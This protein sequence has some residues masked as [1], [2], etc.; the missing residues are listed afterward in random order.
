MYSTPESN[1][2]SFPSDLAPN[3]HFLET[4]AAVQNHASEETVAKNI[5]DTSP[6]QG[7]A[8]RTD[9]NGGKEKAK[10][11]LASV[12]PTKRKAGYFESA[13][14]PSQ[15]TRRSS[16]RL[17]KGEVDSSTCL[18]LAKLGDEYWPCNII[19]ERDG[20][21]MCLCFVP[22]KNKEQIFF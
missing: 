2:K 6:I 5:I 9:G 17:R 10:K 19:D 15:R 11:V 8:E 14:A 4:E 22:G 21:E 12:I 16:T 18:H 13:T 7:S 3:N 20:K 1:F